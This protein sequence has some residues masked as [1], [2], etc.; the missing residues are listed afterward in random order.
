LKS[1][2]GHPRLATRGARLPA[3]ASAGVEEAQGAAWKRKFLKVQKVLDTA[4]ETF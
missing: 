1:C 4:F 2:G 3:C